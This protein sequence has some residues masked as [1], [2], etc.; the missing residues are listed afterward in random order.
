MEKELAP[1]HCDIKALAQVGEE[2][3]GEGRLSGLL[4]LAADLRVDGPDEGVRW[5]VR[6]EKRTSLAGAEDVWL[7]LKVE[8]V[9]P[10]I[11]QRCLGPVDVPVSVNRWFRFV[12]NEELALAQDEEFDEDLLVM[13]REF[14]LAELIEDELLMDAPTVPRHPV[15]PFAVKLSVV[16]TD[17]EESNADKAN[18]FAVLATL[19]GAKSGG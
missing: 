2:L 19:Q 11:C 6:A 14:N 9:L 7:H 4:R 10:L 16:D 13:S 8:T 18:P 5:R 12:A 15:C 1:T 3:T 17:F